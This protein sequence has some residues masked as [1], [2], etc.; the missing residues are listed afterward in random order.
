MNFDNND[1][2]YFLH[3]FKG[4]DTQPGNSGNSSNSGAGNSASGFTFPET[5][6]ETGGTGNQQGSSSITPTPAKRKRHGWRWFFIIMFA[7]LCVTIYIRYFVPYATESRTTGF[8]TRVEKRGIIFKT[9]EG[10]M[11][12]QSQLTDTTRIYSRD[13]LFSIPDDSLA[14][15]LQTHEGSGRPVTITCKRYFG[16]LPWRGASNTIVTAI[17]KG[18]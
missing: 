18:K 1:N 13:F 12:S 7:A 6:Q 10:E 5:S 8:V 16:T 2:D 3:D 15:E 14:R 4:G 9:F 11:I 17:E